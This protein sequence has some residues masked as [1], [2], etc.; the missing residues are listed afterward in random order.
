[1]NWPEA[2]AIAVVAVAAIGLWVFFWSLTKPLM[3]SQIIPASLCSCGHSRK[4]H[5]S[6]GCTALVVPG[7]ARP[8]LLG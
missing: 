4:R 3:K 1:M 5:H 8:A 6:A 2:F 7:S